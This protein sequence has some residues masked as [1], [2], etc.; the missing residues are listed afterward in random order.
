MSQTGVSLV[1]VPE[2]VTEALVALSALVILP[3]V[4]APSAD[5]EPG[6][7]DDVVVIEVPTAN[8]EPTVS[9]VT[10]MPELGLA[11]KGPTV[12]RMP[13]TLEWMSAPVEQP[14]T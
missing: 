8:M 4:E 12:S 6:D 9:W 10:L 13:P 5:E 2:I 1:I 11:N 14:S 7:R 3:P